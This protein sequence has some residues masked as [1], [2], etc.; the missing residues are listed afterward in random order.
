MAPVRRAIGS[1]GYVGGPQ[2][3][4]VARKLLRRRLRVR[5]QQPGSHLPDRYFRSLAVWGL[6]AR[7]TETS[8][9]T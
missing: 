4:S 5:N 2:I 8:D 1:F 6:D 3:G 7:S 9:L